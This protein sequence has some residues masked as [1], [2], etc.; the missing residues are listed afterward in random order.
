MIHNKAVTRDLRLMFVIVL[1]A[2]GTNVAH[3]QSHHHEEDT[4]GVVDF[5]ISCLPA[6]QTEF[7]RAVTLLHHMT[8]PQ[9]REAFQKIAEHDSGCAMVY[10]GIAMTL[11]QP[12]WPTRPGTADLQRG[13]EAV[14]RARALNPPTKREQL[15]IAAAEGFFREPAP[16]DYWNRVRE[17]AQGMEACY[18]AFP[19]DHEVDAFY[20]LSL[21]ATVRPDQISSPNNA[22]AADILLRV[23]KENHRHPGAMHYLIH[24]N[25]V[26]G[27][28]HESLDILREYESIAPHNPHALHMPTHIYTRL[29]DWQEVVRGNIKAAEAALEFP[30]GD[31]RQF[32]WDEFPHA[33]EYLIYAY[34]QMGADDAAAAQLKRLLGTPRLEP[35]FKTAFHLSST[36][37]RYALERKAW[38]EAAAIVPREGG[39]VDWDRFPWPEAISWFAHGLGSVHIGDSAD[40]R[41]SRNRLAELEDA[42]AKAKEELF[43]RNI[44]VLR[45]ELT[46]WLVYKQ[47]MNDS[48]VALMT[49]AAEVETSTPKHAVTPGGTLPAYELLGDLLLDQGKP[50]EAC[51]AYKR[52]LELYPGRFNS[53]LG[54]ARS[55]RAIDSLQTATTFYRRLIDGTS[56]ESKREVLQE[57]RA[58]LSGR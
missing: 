31:H 12:L 51:N 36:R 48:S 53:L 7:N 16:G 1:L 14:Q 5:S 4:L 39:T 56:V 6:S 26:P 11:F 18:A 13:W 30:A 45:T 2:A 9:A 42:A 50:S 35:T 58:F 32:I 37:A 22:R 24:A 23:L 10:W 38:T 46:A 20:A 52:S 15:L 27:R 25:D 41:R 3:G 34:L 57:A 40:A 28:E 49:K 43:A 47:G 33:I 19:R 54:A 8:Y 21:L 29:G 17:W 44:R 55:A